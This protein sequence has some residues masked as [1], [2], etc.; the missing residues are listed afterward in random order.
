M[1]KGLKKSAIILIVILALC[2][3]SATVY[4]RINSEKEKEPTASAY[5]YVFFGSYPQSEVTDKNT[6][7]KLSALDNLE[8]QSYGYYSGNGRYGS[9]EQNDF[10]KYADV[11]LNQEM[12]RAVTF[13]N[14]RPECTFCNPGS[15]RTQLNNNYETE[16]IYWFKF[17]PIK[18][19]ILD[20]NSGLV[21]SEYVLDSQAYS[22]TV[23][24]LASENDLNGDFWN[25]EVNTN[26]ANDYYTSSIRKWLNDDF[27]NTA[28]GKNEKSAID[29]THLDN[30]AYNDDSGKYNGKDCDDKI[31]LL[32]FKDILNTQYGFNPDPENEDISR[33]ASGTDYAKCQGLGVESFMGNQ[34]ELLTAEGKSPAEW[35]LR[36]AGSESYSAV[37]VPYTGRAVNYSYSGLVSITTYGI[38]PALKFVEGHKFS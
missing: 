11:S 14:E 33:R 20:K 35:W 18:W 5:E 27:Y 16:K 9:M 37:C 30:S 2:A 4:S 25:D 28:F 1:N 32:S 31:F 26:Y 13:S 15:T 7:S 24:S 3:V 38:R 34:K 29:V 19:R 17:E 23:Y 10:M 36:S 12:Y 6:I 21:M 22:N 8:W